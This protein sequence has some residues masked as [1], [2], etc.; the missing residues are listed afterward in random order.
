LFRTVANTTGIALRNARILQSLRDE[1]KQSMVLRHEAE[2][3]LR[4]LQRYADFFESAADGICVMDPEGRLL[5]VNRR[6]L[7]ITGYSQPELIG[8]RLGHFL[9][10]EERVRA[11]EILQRISLGHFPQ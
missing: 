10:E 5:F 6:A 11:A 3:R 1:S 9:P 7:E 4:A 8:Q 2:R